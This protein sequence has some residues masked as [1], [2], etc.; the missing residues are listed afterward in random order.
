MFISVF[1]Y[2]CLNG[3]HPPEMQRCW[4]KGRYIKLLTLCLPGRKSDQS[5]FRAC[6]LFPLT[7]WPN[8]FLEH[9]RNYVRKTQTVTT[10]AQP[11]KTLD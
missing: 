8:I 6:L 9:M 10:G 4:H 1:N 3:C 2:V 7:N 5:F 11:V